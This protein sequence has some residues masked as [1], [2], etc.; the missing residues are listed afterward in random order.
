MFLR[1]TLTTLGRESRSEPGS[2]A[3]FVGAELGEATIRA[4]VFDG[5]GRLL[6]KAKRSPKLERGIPAVVE[7]VARC[8][9]DA[10][11]ECDLEL[12]AIKA[13]GVGLEVGV[14]EQ[15]TS[16]A[17]TLP[18]AFSNEVVQAE[19]KKLLGFPAF[20]ETE[21]QLAA[22]GIYETELA[23]NP[24]LVV[25]IVCGK[26]LGGGLLVKGDLPSASLRQPLTG[27]LHE[28]QQ[29]MVAQL[30][31][32]SVTQ[33]S[34]AKLRKA[35]RRRDPRV[36]EY[37]RLAAH[38]AGLAAANILEQLKP[39]W[40]VMGGGLLDELKNDMMPII[41]ETVRQAA[42]AM[43]DAPTRILASELADNAVMVG[44]AFYA[45]RRVAG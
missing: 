41:L 13:A 29:Q 9:R 21:Y 4:G 35:A 7:R 16:P 42:P 18:P 40:V 44:A 3:L 28:A 31:D 1:K 32:R 33:L 39:D 30:P 23:G 6:G 37:A 43:T 36:C 24:G 15:W 17:A 27:L 5:A 38:Q 14:I 20:L 34:K 45:R 8:I 11:D 22:L 19:L 25:T 2:D 12:D 26:E 10:V